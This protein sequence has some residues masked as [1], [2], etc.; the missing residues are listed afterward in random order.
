[1]FW[2]IAHKWNTLHLF[3]RKEIAK[4]KRNEKA[5]YVFIWK[6]LQDI[7]TEKKAM[8]DSLRNV[9]FWVG[10]EEPENVYLIC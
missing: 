4:E 1:M 10:R 3:E 2:N 7:L 9:I 6:F 5:I 8:Q